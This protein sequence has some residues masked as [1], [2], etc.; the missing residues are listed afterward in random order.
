MSYFAEGSKPAF[1]RRLSLF[2]NFPTEAG[3]EQCEW[4]D[5]RPVGHVTHRGA[6]EFNISGTSTSYLDLKRTRLFARA[7]ILNEDG[8]PVSDIDNVGF[9]NL[10]LQ[11]L[12]SQVDVTVQQQNISPSISTNYPYKA[13]LDVL[14]QSR[15]DTNHLQSQLF[16]PDSAGS[17]DSANPDTGSNSGLYLRSNF[18]KH[19]SYVDLEGPVY[20]DVCQQE[21]L[22]IN[23][24]QVVFKFWPSRDTFCLMTDDDETRYKISIDDSVLRCCFV[25]VN[26]GVILGHNQ[27]LNQQQAMYPFKKS[28]IKCFG[29]PA[30][31]YSLNVDDVFHGEIP[32]RLVVALVSSSA[33]SGN[34]KSNPFNFQHFNC[35]YAAF[36]VDGKSV[37]SSPLEPGYSTNNYISAYLTLFTGTGKYLSDKGSIIDR[38][39]YPNG[40]CLYVFDVNSVYDEGSNIPLLKKGHSRINLKFE[41]PLPEAVTCICYGQ[42]PS[43]LRIDASRNVE[44]K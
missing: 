7:R 29:I 21:R 13:M 12:W 11:S 34:Y 16:F 44:L 20:I 5:V 23:G 26:P 14:L 38:T 15:K 43:V 36:Y 10:T 40:Y 35:N 41:K 4:V 18:T 17:M 30:G 8:S 25:K 19:G 3:I 28:D 6:I 24:V 31:Q 37:P 32:E 33:Y 1:S 2:H 39:D 27:S 22:M 9:V 42:F